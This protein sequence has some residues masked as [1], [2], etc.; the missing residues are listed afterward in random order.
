[1]GRKTP[2]PLENFEFLSEALKNTRVHI[3]TQ[4]PCHIIMKQYKHDNLN[5]FSM[6]GITVTHDFVEATKCSFCQT[7]YDTKQALKKTR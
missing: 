7:Q 3:Q 2:P 6:F 4:M 1:M 5:L